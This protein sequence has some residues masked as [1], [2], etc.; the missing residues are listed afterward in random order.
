VEGSGSG[1]ILAANPAVVPRD[2]RKPRKMSIRI[3]GIG[4][5]MLTA[6]IQSKSKKV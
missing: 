1:L 4:A 6:R 3:V 5:E 2:R